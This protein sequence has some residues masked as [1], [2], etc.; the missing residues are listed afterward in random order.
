MTNETAVAIPEQT[1]PPDVMEK[2]VIG[3]DLAE[4]NAAQRADYYTAVCRSLG[5][6]PLTKPF[7]FLTLNGKL[8]LY[9]LRDCTDQL[10][11]IHGISIYIASR[12]RMNDIYIVTARARTRDGREDESTGA[13]TIGNLK[14]DALCNALMKAE[15]KSKRRV[16]L[17]IAGLGWLDET[18][19]ETIPPQALSSSQLVS[20]PAPL[21]SDLSGNG[22]PGISEQIPLAEQH[23]TADEITRLVQCA[24]AANH[25]MEAFGQDMRRLMGLPETQKI[26]K[27]FLREQLT[28]AQYE[29]ARAHYGQTLAEILNQDV[30]DFPP[31]SAPEDA[32]PASD[33]TPA[34]DSAEKDRA[35]VRE[36]ALGWGLPAKEIDFI[37]AHHRDPQHARNILWNAKQHRQQQ[38]EPQPPLT[39]AAD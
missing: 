37:M 8:R 10:R 29:K 12:E 19:L 9:A 14:G 25:S 2:V 22:E 11:R 31:A 15:T 35:I 26:M 27:K 32:P 24:L 5:L 38:P 39:E 23:P 16:T 6:N 4:L 21:E 34:E 7:K 13:V 30:P 33:A 20:S 1:L 36:L 18:E 3:G 28:M 17:S